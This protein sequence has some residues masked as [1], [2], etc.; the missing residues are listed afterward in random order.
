MQDISSDYTPL[1][2]SDLTH[3]EAMIVCIFRGWHEHAPNRE[4]FETRI[5]DR[6]QTSQIYAAL[7]E[8][9]QFFQRFTHLRLVHVHDNAV[10]S[11][12]EEHLLAILGGSIDTPGLEG[13]ALEC[14]AKL[15]E[16]QITPRPIEILGGGWEAQN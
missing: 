1:G 3:D 16:V 10:L 11:P 5:R 6:L 9:F 8:I 12:T 7:T 14:R 15:N 4:L 2:F 13:A